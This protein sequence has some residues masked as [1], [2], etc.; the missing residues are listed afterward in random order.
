M[1]FLGGFVAMNQLEQLRKFSTVVADTGEI[2]AIREY[3]PTDATTN[4][5]LLL[6]AAT[7]PE[8][9]HLVDDAVR[10]GASQSADQAQRL[11]AT[12]DKLAVNFGTE[13][14]KI[15]PGRVSTEVDARLSFDAKTSL[16]KAH[17][18]ISL[19]EKAGVGKERVLIKLAA[20][21]E[22]IETAR[23]L[24]Q[25]GIHCNMTLMFSLAQAVAC[26]EAKATLISPFVGRIYDWYK[27][28]DGVADYPAA[29]D[30]GVLFV[31]RVYAYFKKFG[32]TTEIMGASFRKASQ[33]LELAGCDLLTVAPSLLNELRGNDAPVSQ[34]LTVSMLENQKIERL[35][36]DEKGFRW[37]MNEDAMATEKLADGIRRFAQD[38]RKLESELL[39]RGI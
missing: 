26:A 27:Q 28:H 39:K 16:A 14:L 10:Y 2:S 6:A 23:I 11:D 5:T 22:G 29:Q 30:P 4:P 37:A 31:T 25:E 1:S 35:L 34:K 13:I 33:V 19:Y 32:Y 8:Y 17:R 7:S 24:E 9:T 15:I 21:W 18:L 20:T 36:A 3:R 12:M 38:A